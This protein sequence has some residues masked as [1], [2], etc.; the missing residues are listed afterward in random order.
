MHK[1]LAAVS[2]ARVIV[3][4][5]PL[6]FGAPGKTFAVGASSFDV[7]HYRDAD[8]LQVTTSQAGL[9][10]AIAPNW[11]MSAKMLW[12]RLSFAPGDGSMEGSGHEHH[13]MKGGAGSVE[14]G[15]GQA[16]QDG[17]DH[18][19]MEDI[20]GGAV[21][22]ISGASR[23]A[24][25]SSSGAV[26]HRYEVMAGLARQVGHGSRPHRIGGK[27]QVSY[28]DDYVAVTGIADAAVEL[29][30]R[31]VTLS[32]YAGFGYDY[33]NPVKPPPGEASEWPASQRRYLTGFG[34]SQVTGRRSTVSV[35]YGL[36][37][38]TGKLESPYRR[39]T[40][41]TT[42]FSESLPD[43]R[44]RHHG[45]LTWAFTP[46]PGLALHHR[47]G[48]YYDSW[49]YHAYIPETALSWQIFAAH[50]LTLRHRYV[51]QDAAEFWQHHYDDLQGYRSGDYR[52][53]GLN[54]HAVTAEWAWRR[55]FDLR[56]LEVSGHITRFWQDSQASQVSPEGYLFGLSVAWA[57]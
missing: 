28:E 36:Q 17:H 43:Q 53:A 44:W 37:V 25:G 54:H 31:N 48:L 9:E 50:M 56:L 5:A 46:M 30:Q 45:A 19:G 21:D 47:Q 41:I 1:L 11:L 18:E 10:Q 14:A 7:V 38:L 13:L 2:P 40:V 52:L 42:E 3:S 15:A 33:V 34:Y 8:G 39:A 26:Q 51:R 32:G 27:A 23:R 4:L 20:G 35:G 12:D 29:W 6:L 49:N 16:A 57:W 55:D 24:A 22:G